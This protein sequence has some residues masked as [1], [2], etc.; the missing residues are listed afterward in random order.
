[1]MFMMWRIFR[2]KRQGAMGCWRNLYNEL[3]QYAAHRIYYAFQVSV[4]KSG[5]KARK[6]S[7]YMDDLKTDLEE[8][9]VKGTD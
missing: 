6:T 2:P 5:E 9:G 1:M 3:A 8:N 7:K 4:R